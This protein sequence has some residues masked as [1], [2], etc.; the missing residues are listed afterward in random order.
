[1]PSYKVKL[2]CKREIAEETMAFHFEKPEG[3]IYKAGQ[4]ADC[5]LINPDETDTE[6]NTRA[7]SLASAPYEDDLMVATR[8]RDTAFKRV[9]KTMELGM[10]MTLNAPYGSFTLHNNESVPA[11]FLTGGIGITPVRSIVLQAIHDRV[12][13]R[14][15]VFYSNRK[16]EDAAFLDDLKE[17]RTA[18]PNY[19][20]VGTMTQME[21]SSREWHGETGVISKAMLLKFID[22]LTFPIYYIDGPPAMVK[23]IRQ[24]LSEAGVDD[25]NIRTEEFSGY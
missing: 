6:G 24:I 7:F 5:T 14:I 23:A 12:S 19:T 13:H 3:F 22:D 1:M 20:F 9:L 17:S 11:V 21:K 25:D 18:N 4:F 10:E 15:L 8:M 2:K 16:P